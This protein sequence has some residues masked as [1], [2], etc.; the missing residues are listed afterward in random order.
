MPAEILILAHGGNDCYTD[1]FWQIPA[2][3]GSGEGG[4]GHGKRKE[5]VPNQHYTVFWRDYDKD[6]VHMCMNCSILGNYPFCKPGQVH[7]SIF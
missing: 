6:M 4:S 3:K 2:S 5:K 7:T 1:F